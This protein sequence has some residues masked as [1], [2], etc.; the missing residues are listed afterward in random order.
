MG[1]HKVWLRLAGIKTLPPLCSRQVPGNNEPSLRSIRLC[2]D[3]E[4]SNGNDILR[5]A[6]GRNPVML[7]QASDSLA[8]QRKERAQ[9]VIAQEKPDP[10]QRADND[11]HEIWIANA[12]MGCSCPTE[13]PRQ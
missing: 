8:F 4:V 10:D 6:H 1:T 2:D 3:T 9:P 12:H 7:S 13:I 5:W 11:R